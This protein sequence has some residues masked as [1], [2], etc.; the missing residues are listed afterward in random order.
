MGMSRC[1]IAVF[2]ALA[3]AGGAANAAAD[4]PTA[5]A[6]GGAEH[7]GAPPRFVL[8][9]ARMTVRLGYPDGERALYTGQRFNRGGV[10]AEVVADGRR[11][12]GRWKADVPRGAHDDISGPADEFDIENPPGYA[13]ADPEGG[14]FIKIGVGALR[15]SGPK[16]YQ[17]WTEYPMSDAGA[18]D[19]EIHPGSARYTHRLK[20]D[21]GFA[22]RLAK[23]VHLHPVEPEFTLTYTLVNEGERPLETLQYHHNFCV[24]ENV[25]IVGPEWTA[26]L[27]YAPAWLAPENRHEDVRLEGE[28]LRFLRPLENNRSRWMSL[29]GVDDAARHRIRVAHE[30]EGV[31]IEISGDQPIEKMNVYAQARAVCPEPF[32][33]IRLAP[34]ASKTW[35][36]IYRFSVTRR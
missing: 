6:P 33:R 35:S 18:W 15:R 7:N 2:G 34:G 16:P 36:A 3:L 30:A 20:T 21:I 10:V 27:G 9:N 14:V 4:A 31:A 32:V 23:T 8:E 5:R 1:G 12:F 22:Y 11:F 29:G 26:T 17:F 28:R 13:E 25:E 19:L 24:F